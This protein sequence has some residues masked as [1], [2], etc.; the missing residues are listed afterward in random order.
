M[1]GESGHEAV[2]WLTISQSIKRLWLHDS[3]NVLTQSHLDWRK[4]DKLQWLT[5]CVACD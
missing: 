4:E 3:V 1:E 5:S 2:C